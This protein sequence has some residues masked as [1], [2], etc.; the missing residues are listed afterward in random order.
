MAELQ[1]QFENDAWYPAEV[2]S[3]RFEES[4]GSNTPGVTI[5]WTITEG[6]ML[7]KSIFDQRWISK[8][9]AER[10]VKEF[11]VL[12]FD[13]TK[14]RLHQMSSVIVGKKADIL[15]RVEEFPKNSGTF[16]PKVGRIKPP[17][18]GGEDKL[19]ARLEELIGVQ[20]SEAVNE[21]KF[22]KQF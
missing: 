20:I 21:D 13:R 15:C 10:H 17:G 14:H 5:K 2:E 6:P 3:V 16:T 9:N 8:K 4:G 11:E 7:G 18:A 1:D 12:G 22:E 19:I